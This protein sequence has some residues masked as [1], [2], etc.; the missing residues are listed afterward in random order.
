MIPGVFLVIMAFGLFIA[1]VSTVMQSAAFVFSRRFVVRFG[2]PVELVIY[3]QLWMG[4]MG[5][6]AFA[7]TI[8]R[9]SIPWSREFVATAAVF[10][11]AYNLVFFFFF[12]AM[13]LIEASRLSSLTGLKVI[14]VALLALLFFHE[15][16][17]P[18]RIAAVL[19]TAI[20]AVGMNFSGGRIGWA[21]ASYLF[22]SLLGFATTDVTGAH[23][24]KL[25][26]GASVTL[27]AICVMSLCYCVLGVL[28]GA[29]F[30]RK[31]FSQ[32]LFFGAFP[33]SVLWFSAMMLLFSS[34]GII[35]VVFGTIIQAGRGV[36]SVLFG[37]ALARCCGDIE[38]KVSARM[39][40]RRAVMSLVM[41]SAMALYSLS[42]P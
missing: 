25:M 35:G 38:P 9:T 15:R 27:E 22:L 5:A 36:I 14:V 7:A 20:A 18:G 41:L 28:S 42:R 32:R 11:L 34:F 23:L 4:I 12:K 39:W 29:V 37:I 13:S 24:V 17:T 8:C 1:A 33:Y 26:P 31:Q 19:L 21:G 2:S 10:V 16:L 30:V 6:A 40:V 3:S